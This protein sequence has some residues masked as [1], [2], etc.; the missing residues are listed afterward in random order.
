MGQSQL[1][2]VERVFVAAFWKQ[3]PTPFRRRLIR[4]RRGQI[5]ERTVK[6]L[7]SSVV[8]LGNS[9]NNE[10]GNPIQKHM[11]SLSDTVTTKNG[12][13]GHSS[14]QTQAKARD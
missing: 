11:G 10:K 13:C 2:P 12:T 3:K 4:K 5:L 7:V 8:L 6:Y 14:S 9:I 1:A